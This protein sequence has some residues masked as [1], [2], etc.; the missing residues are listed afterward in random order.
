MPIMYFLNFYDRSSVNLFI[1]S[2]H[3]PLSPFSMGVLCARFI[4][5]GQIV[6]KEYA[7]FLK[8]SGSRNY[9]SAPWSTTLVQSCP[10]EYCTVR[11][12]DVEFKFLKQFKKS[13]IR[14]DRLHKTSKCP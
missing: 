12:G 3:L 13:S 7:L 9:D 11:V 8:M 14:T 5:I 4:K 1:Y 6:Q 2:L 10:Q